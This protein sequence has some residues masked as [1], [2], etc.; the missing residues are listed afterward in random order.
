MKNTIVAEVTAYNEHDDYTP[1]TTMANGE[2]VHYGAVAND[3]LPMGTL[4]EINGEIF[5]VSDRFG[6]DHPVERFDIY[7]PSKE[8]CLNY[9][10][11]KIIIEIRE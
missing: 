10:Q 7:M 8:L 2:T 1:G 6:A 5:E 3:V 4:V 9:G 11:Q